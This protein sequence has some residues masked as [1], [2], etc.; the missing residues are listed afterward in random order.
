VPGLLHRLTVSEV[1]RKGFAPRP[2]LKPVLFQA[3]GREHGVFRSLG[4]PG[5]ILGMN[6]LDGESYR[7]CSAYRFARKLM[8]GTVTSIA[9]VEDSLR[10]GS[11][12]LDDGVS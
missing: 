10:V 4:R 2:H 1:I 7:S 3:M 6:R 9:R 12:E 5:Q 11:D 8:P